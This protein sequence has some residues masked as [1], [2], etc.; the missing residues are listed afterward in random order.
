[1]RHRP[2]DHGAARCRGTLVVFR[3][4]ATATEP[5]KRSLNDP[6]PFQH[7]KP[8]LLLR[9]MNDFY[10]TAKNA[11]H[12]TGQSARVPCIGSE[13]AKP[14]KLPLQGIQ[15]PHR[16]PLIPHRR[17]THEAGHDHSHRV[18]NQMTLAPFHLFSC[19]KSTDPPFFSR[20]YRLA[21][22]NRN[23]WLGVPPRRLPDITSKEIVE[24]LQRPVEAPAPV[25]GM[26]GGV[27]WEVARQ[28]SP[29]APSAEHVENRIHD[30]PA[31]CGRRP[32]GLLRRKQRSDL[33]PLRIGQVR[34]IS[35]SHR[36]MPWN[37]QGR[38]TLQ[39]EHRGRRKGRLLRIMS[40]FGS[41]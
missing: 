28:V 35:P 3:E 27:G 21:V 18:N 14:R 4:P 9:S 2:K 11:S 8:F 10:V 31:V 26:N 41:L 39:A 16:P 30:L 25:T 19:V 38:G 5:P 32:T 33:F 15:C 1:M 29:L 7:H 34:R 20:L 37:V 17:C 40:E 36:F 12:P 13:K 6:A 24:A 23:A 22:Y